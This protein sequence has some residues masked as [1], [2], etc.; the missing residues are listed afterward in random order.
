MRKRL[1]LNSS[2]KID[3]LRF[4]VFTPCYNSSTFI[5]RVFNSLQ[6][7][8]FRD[9]EWLV[10]ND[11][12]TDNTSAQ[13]KEFIKKVDFPVQFYDLPENQ[14]LHANIN[15]AIEKAKGDYLV[16]FG[17]DDEMLP[18]ALQ[19]FY[20]VL[21]KYETK[22]ISAVYGLAK[23]QNGELVGKLYPRQ[24]QISDYWTQF[25]VLE[26]EAEKFQCFRVKYL[27]EFYPLKIEPE[28]ALP[29]SWL[30]G[31]LGGKYK[32]IF[33]NEILRIYYT[34]V[35][36][37]ITNTST[38]NHRPI[39]VYNYYTYW[40]NEFQFLIKGNAKRRLRGIGGYVSYGLR[41]KKGTVDLIKRPDRILDKFL[42]IV[43]LPIAI[44]YNIRNK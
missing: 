3:K 6:E 33:I 31:K 13:I 30:W 29:S 4:T 34:N 32:A 28:E 23:D 26:N 19:T 21:E 40:I 10:V 44:I 24:F 11:A 1:S 38:R 7:Q 16:L 8:T 2:N 12:S 9:F 36:T 27:R 17:H 5:S 35:T 18:H 20:D 39:A 22:E 43:F 41:S 14:G 42:V 15:L 25:M 37:S